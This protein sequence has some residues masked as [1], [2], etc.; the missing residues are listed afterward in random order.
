MPLISFADIEL[1]FNSY[2]IPFLTALNIINNAILLLFFLQNRIIQRSLP[3]PV[4]L[5]YIAM[6]VN[7]INNSIY[8]QISHFL[9]TPVINVQITNVLK[10]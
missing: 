2:I 10:N 6:A 8:M 3:K 4:Y 1:L 5:N 9:G 7:D